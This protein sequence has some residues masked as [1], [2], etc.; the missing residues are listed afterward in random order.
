MVGSGA[1]A[2][3]SALLPAGAMAAMAGRL[4]QSPPV[5]NEAADW[6]VQAGASAA[7]QAL[8]GR[9]VAVLGGAI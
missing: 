9:T 3:V 1:Q 4:R 7:A 2:V 6:V 5:D 8:L